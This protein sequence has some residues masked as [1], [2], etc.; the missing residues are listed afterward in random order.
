MLIT[1]QN[2]KIPNRALS[3]IIIGHIKNIT[4]RTDPWRKKQFLKPGYFKNIIKIQRTNVGNP[5]NGIDL[6]WSSYCDM[7]IIGK[8]S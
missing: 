3:N 5:F 1:D 6:T 8:Y 2:S 7:G 4:F